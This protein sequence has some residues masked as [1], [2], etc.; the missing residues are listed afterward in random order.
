MPAIPDTTLPNISHKPCLFRNS[1]GTTQHRTP[2]QARYR[3]PLLPRC[4]DTHDP[5]THHTG[6]RHRSRDPIQKKHGPSYLFTTNPFLSCTTPSLSTYTLPAL[7]RGTPTTTP[8]KPT[9]PATT[10]KKP[11]EPATTPKKPGSMFCTSPVLS[12][13]INPFH[14][15]GCLY[16]VMTPM[17]ATTWTT[18]P[19]CRKTTST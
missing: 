9:E 5:P 2:K 6:E 11:T 13:P 7:S 17:T 4:N 10:P 16:A 15:H 19:S 12:C 1:P 8:K 14:H 3:L 18:T